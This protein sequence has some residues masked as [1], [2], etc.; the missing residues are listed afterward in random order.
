MSASRM[1]TSDTSGRSSPS[2]SR[3]MPTSTSNGAQAQVAD[4]LHALAAYRYRECIYLH[5]DASISEIVGQV[6]RHLLG[7]RGHKHALAACDAT[8]LYL[9]EQVVDLSLRL[10]CTMIVRIQ[11]ARWDG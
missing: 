5:L 1:A 9:A 10:G 3:L 6:L 8:S 4:D 2:R 11:K 7:Q